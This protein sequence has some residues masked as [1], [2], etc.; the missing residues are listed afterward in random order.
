M[1]LKRVWD[2]LLKMM[3]SLRFILLILGLAGLWMG[4][5]LAVGGFE[6][7]ARHFGLP[8]LF[9]GLTVMAVG[10]PR[11]AFVGGVPAGL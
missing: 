3:D 7:V 5:Q 11:V 4:S 1:L 9:I 2:G 10:P 6:N 8:R